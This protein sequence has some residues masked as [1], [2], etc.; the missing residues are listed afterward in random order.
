MGIFR[1]GTM[2]NFNEWMALFTAF[3][4]AYAAYRAREIRNDQKF[5]ATQLNNKKKKKLVKSMLLI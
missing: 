5:Y 4:A 3:F 2:I 1:L